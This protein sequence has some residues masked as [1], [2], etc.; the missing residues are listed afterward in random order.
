MNLLFSIHLYYPRHSAGAE[1]YV[2]SMAKEMIKRGHEVKIILHQANQHK[3]TE[4]YDFEGVMVF[5][6]DPY[7][8]ERLFDW[9]DVVLS[10]LDYNKWTAWEC[11]KRNKKFVHIV[12]ND[13]TY[14]SVTDSPCPTKVIY[15][16]EWTKKNLNYKWDSIVF[17]PPVNTDTIAEN[18]QKKY[19]AMVNLN[20]NKGAAHFYSVAKKMPEY[21]FLAIKGSYDNQLLSTLPNV[22]TVNPTPYIREYYKDVAVLC[23]LS[24]YESWG[25]VATEGMLNGIPVIA[26][27]TEGLKENLS[28]AGIFVDRK[29]TQSIVNELKKLMTDEAYYNKWAKKGLKRAKELAPKWDEL[30]QFLLS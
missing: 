21:Q 14:P 23:M 5:P 12:H 29:D 15:N 7:M 1:S 17:P 18:R 25:L 24:H 16:A 11:A 20:H 27:P 6:P 19:I 28:Y 10:H 9:A 3:I 8:I 30:E 4:M 22:K 2:R 13:I 26:T